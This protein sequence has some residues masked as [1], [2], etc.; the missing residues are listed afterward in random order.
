MMHLIKARLQC[1]I[2]GLGNTVQ[3]VGPM[4]TLLGIVRYCRSLLLFLTWY[5]VNSMG[6]L[7][8]VLVDLENGS[9]ETNKRNLP[10]G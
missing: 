3:F 6:L 2:Q 8:I 5:I 1:R 9:L 10:W 4:D 7:L